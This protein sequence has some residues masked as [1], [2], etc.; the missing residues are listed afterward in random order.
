VTEAVSPAPRELWLYI[1]SRFAG[2]L[3]IQVQSVAIGWQVY[4]R[5]GNPLDLGWVGLSQFLPLALLS[6]WAGSV[7]DR[8][9]RKRML[10]ASRAGFAVGSLALAGL[11]L[12]PHEWGILP[13]Y[14]VLVWLG[15]TR[16]F[17][18]PASSALL[19]AL[20][21]PVHLPRAIG[22]S[23]TTFQV[24][25]IAGPAVGG[26]V[27]AAGDAI[28][29]YLFAAASELVSVLLLLSIRRALPRLE[30]PAERGLALLLSGVR[31]VWRQKVLLGAISLDLFA[32]L[33]GGAVALMPI[34]ARDILHVGETGLGLLRSAPAV[35]AA[36]V[37]AVLAAFPIRRRA[38][39]F[40]FGGVAL[41]GLATIAFGLSEH[42]VLSLVALAVLGGADMISVVIR[43]S[44][45]Q[46]STPDAMRG[47]VASVNMIFIGASNEL[48]EL[49]SG[50][51]AAWLGTVRAV[52]VGGIGTLM[53][54]GL[55][56]VLFPSLRRA[57]TVEEG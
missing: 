29:A 39:L 55:W 22:L 34:F 54:T 4:S 30:V 2:T 17:A 19:P 21:S 3:G 7:A 40:M 47:R 28:G 10:V 23:S 1:G 15:A 50:V 42:F 31:Y 8:V 12:A 11:T 41:F 57:E 27:Y 51:T 20:V 43:Q 13:I 48:G 49:E 32:V 9:D 14:A 36:I 52:V 16:A 35:G 46:L 25:T 18:A 45:V 38:G 33:L 44:I 26:L 6:L 24:A 5:T 53:V 37:A 56:A